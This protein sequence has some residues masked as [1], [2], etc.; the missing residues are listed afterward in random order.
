MR[1]E[2]DYMKIDAD[3]SSNSKRNEHICETCSKTF[4]KKSCLKMHI[5][6]SHVVLCE[7]K[8]ECIQ[9]GNKY[10]AQNELKVDT[11]ICNN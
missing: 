3:E 11:F 2:A 9:C 4:K 5:L 10:H 1:D 8:F 6:R 7:K